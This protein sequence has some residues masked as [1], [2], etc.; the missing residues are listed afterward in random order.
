MK[1]DL[2][3]PGDAAAIELTRNLLTGFPGR[4]TAAELDWGIP[5]LARLAIAADAGTSAAEPTRQAA[6]AAALAWSAAYRGRMT[7]PALFGWGLAGYAVGLAHAAVAE[8]RL[9]TVAHAARDKV[10]TWCRESEP[11]KAGLAFA[12]YDLI[13]GMSGV[14]LALASLPGCLPEHVG[15]GLRYLAALCRDPALA[16][17]VVT[18]DGGDPRN[19]W[20]VGR[21]N[22]GL[23]HGAPGVLAA[24]VAAW[25]LARPG[26]RDSVAAAIGALASYLLR[27]S[28]TDSRGVLTWPPASG[29]ERQGTTPRRQAWCYGAPGVAWQLAEAGRVLGDREMRAC[30]AASIISLCEAWDDDYYLVPGPASARLGFCHGAAGILAVARLFG[31]GLGLAQADRLA[32]HLAG[33]LGREAGRVRDLANEDLTLLSGAAG[34]LAVQL[35]PAVPAPGWQLPIGLGAPEIGAAPVD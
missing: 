29:Q 31:R 20:C 5:L 14:V 24:L 23:A 10:V 34:A 19:R 16:G 9:A 13:I 15:P 22:L 2:A 17:L 32:E 27:T 6:R 35:A 1:A 4:E 7:Q 18:A 33:L 11:G 21:L 8:P 12:D 28:A 30:A 3:G 26:D 25:P